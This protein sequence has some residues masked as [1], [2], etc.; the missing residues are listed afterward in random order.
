MNHHPNYIQ[1]MRALVPRLREVPKFSVWQFEP[2]CD[3]MAYFWNKGT[4]SFVLDGDKARGVCTIKLFSRLEQFLEPFVHEPG[5]QYAMIEALVGDGPEVFG[6]LLK[7]LIGRWGHPPIV[8]WDRGL[9]TEHG[10]PRMFTWQGF[11]KLA[12]RFAHY[13]FSA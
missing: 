8:M 9:R 10:A 5:G 3:W 12:R 2:I 1:T 7:D 4:I 6:L 11:E 13:G